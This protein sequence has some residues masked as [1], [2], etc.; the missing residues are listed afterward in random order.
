MSNT[1]ILVI[2]AHPDLANSRINRRLAGGVAT[3]PNVK[4]E[5]LYVDYP[6]G[7]IDVARE[8]EAVASSDVI[9]FQFPFYWYAA[10]ALLKEWQDKVLGPSWSSEQFRES[11]AAKKS[12]VVVTMAHGATTYLRG[13]ENHYTVEE[14]MLPLRQMAN[15]CGM[16]WEAPHAIYGVKDFSDEDIDREVE[17]YRELL[18]KY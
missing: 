2:V 6:N 11:L 16:I 4:V 12:L 13:A 5:K 10:P 9:V 1:K 17:V 15:F 7:V 18:G 14:S 8:Q 3:L